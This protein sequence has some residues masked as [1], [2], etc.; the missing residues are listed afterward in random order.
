[1]FE[2]T[3]LAAGPRVISAR[4]PGARSVSIAAYV[5]AGSRLETDAAGRR[6]P[7]HGAP[8]VQG[9][10]RA[11]PRRERSARRS[12]ASAARSTRR[13]T[14][15]R[16]STGSACR[17]ARSARAMD[18]LGELIVRP[19]L[20]DA[21]DR[22]RADGHRRGDPLVPRRPVGVL[23]D[24]LPERAVRR[25]PARVARSAA[26]RTA[27]GPC[28]AKTIRAFWRTAYRPANTVV[29]VAGD[30]SHDGCGR[31]RRRRRSGRATARCPGSRPRRPCRPA[32]GRRRQARHSAGPAVPRAAGAPSRPP[33]QLD[34][35]RP[36]RRAGR[37]D[38]QPPLPVRARGAGSGL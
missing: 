20:D 31:P 10:G 16:P 3:A 21:R 14:A 26:T 7:L 18:V 1:M 6:G 13:P 11:T 25:R 17:A 24:P 33:R 9:H 36:Q 38:E 8:D 27:S 5:L 12:R 35:R 32:A 37:R 29:A 15:S 22:E 34:A 19:T 23:P 28:P 4:M 30:L 2:R